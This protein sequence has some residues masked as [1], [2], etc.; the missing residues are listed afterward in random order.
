MRLKGKLQKWNEEKAFGF[1]TPNGGG[2]NIF[3]HKSAFVNRQRTPQKNEVITFAISQD[4][5]G[6]YCASDATFTGEKLKNKQAKKVNKFSIYLSIIFLI[7]IITAYALGYIPRNLLLFYYSASL[8]T[9]IS[10][11]YDKF[12]ARRN[13]WRITENTLHLLALFG[14][15]PGAAIAQQTLRHKSQKQKFR[16]VF[17][18]TV[19]INCAAL[20]WL[21]TPS[22]TLI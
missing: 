6:R 7:L 5:Q 8:I 21:L 9:F 20:I 16:F 15:W 11:A 2:D 3:I 18:L 19:I 17:W 14:G 13:G 1:I 10:Y 4:N 22:S 12:K